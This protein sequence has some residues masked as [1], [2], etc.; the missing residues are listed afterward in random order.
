MKVVLEL[1]MARPQSH[2]GGMGVELKTVC[3]A[4]ENNRIKKRRSGAS[5]SQE[6]VRV[7][8]LET[9]VRFV[10]WIFKERM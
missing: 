2:M 4:E 6:V 3:G 9:M 8:I 1:R 7:Q 10:L 5:N